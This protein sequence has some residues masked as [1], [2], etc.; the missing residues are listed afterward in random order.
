MSDEESVQKGNIHNL[1]PDSDPILSQELP[2]FDFDNPA[3]DPIQLA[4]DLVESMRHHNGLGL[5]ANQI[6]LP[7]RAFAMQAVPAIV[8]FNPKV[9]D[10]SSEE[11]M[12]EEGCLSFPG[13]GIKIKRPRHIKVRYTEPNGN[14]VTRKF[15]GMAARCFLHEYD[16]MNGTKYID[17]ASFIQKEIA[18]KRQK[19]LA[20][21]KRV[22]R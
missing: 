2:K 22:F 14:V 4:Y 7:Y 6:G 1:V 12:L 3:T 9:I 16:H 8:C 11:I 17:R 19:K 5:S 10:E 21:L 13:L 15:T 20:K 18:L